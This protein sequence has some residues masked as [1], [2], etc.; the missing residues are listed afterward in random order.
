GGTPLAQGAAQPTQV[1]LVG[2]HQVGAPQLVQLQPVLQEPE[3]PVGAVERRG[4]VAPDV[5]ALAERGEGLQGGA[6]PQ[7]LVG[8]AVDQ[9]QEL[10]AELDVAQSPGAE[11][12]LARS[13]EHTSEL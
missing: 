2:R 11:L 8:A 4:M 7:C 6:G 5:A 9:L 13:E 3:E 1:R 10:D 12:E